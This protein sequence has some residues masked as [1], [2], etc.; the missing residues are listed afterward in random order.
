MDFKKLLKNKFV[1]AVPIAMVLLGCLH[2]FNEFKKLSEKS[3]K[4]NEEKDESKHNIIY[5][6]KAFVICYAVGLC[7]LILLKKGYSYFKNQRNKEVPANLITNNTNEISK[8][9]NNTIDNTE[10]IIM[11]PLQNNDIQLPSQTQQPSQ[12]PQSSLS[13]QLP[14]TL[15]PSPPNMKENNNLS[16]LENL[17]VNEAKQLNLDVDTSNLEEIPLENIKL[18]KPPPPSIEDKKN[19]LLAKRKKLLELKKRKA[20]KSQKGGNNL[21]LEVFNTGTPN[22]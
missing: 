16:L 22:F 5:Y 17:N 6:L 14:Q 3:D 12:T 13:T 19:Q 8:T 15:Q 18:E 2:K 4:E 9:T 10:S 1:I 20:A 7:L 11:D 21:A